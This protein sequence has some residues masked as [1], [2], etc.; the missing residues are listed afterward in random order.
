VAE[1]LRHL[2]RQERRPGQ[3]PAIQSVSA[4]GIRATE[5]PQPFIETF[6]LY[7]S[8]QPLA[9]RT[10]RCAPTSNAMAFVAELH[11][12]NWLMLRARIR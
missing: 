6:A 2:R 9:I 8:V 11:Q 3:G 4:G 7:T 1:S 12:T 10:G 5:F